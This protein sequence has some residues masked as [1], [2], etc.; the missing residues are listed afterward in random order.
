MLLGFLWDSDRHRWVN[1]CG[2]DLGIPRCI[3]DKVL[4]QYEDSGCIFAKMCTWLGLLESRPELGSDT[5]TPHNSE[6][7][8]MLLY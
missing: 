7:K 5:L 6:T 3:V 8:N 4:L 2:V 1:K